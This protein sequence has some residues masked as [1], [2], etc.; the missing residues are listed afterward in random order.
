MKT[1]I[2]NWKMN[3]GVRE[4]VALARGTLL[5]LRGRVVAPELVI[6]PA[7][8]GLSEVHKVVARSSVSLGAQDV[9]W[10][11]QG[12]YTGAVSGRMLTELGVEYV[13]V[14]HSERRQTFG[15]T[16]E[17]IAKKVA[18]VRSHSMTPIVCVGE[19]RAERDQGL[20]RE[21]VQAQVLSA[22]GEVR[23][24][25]REQL[26]MA[27]E[28]VWAIGTGE[29]PDV[30]EVVQMHEFV[31]QLV[32]EVVGETETGS[33]RVLYGGSVDGENAY[34]FLREPEIDGVLV[35]SAS[36]KLNQF[37]DIVKAAADVLESQF[38]SSV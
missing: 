1:I 25:G 32:Q 7:F 20:A 30:A 8:V 2:A 11:E 18:L 35:G 26:M 6:C 17:Q 5:T 34:Q 36:V 10:E 16:D 38:S 12:A 21:R 13:I 23:L 24:R 37:K 19:T 14:G 27:Y 15:E 33:I 29:T 31:R 28:P 4:S 9:F 22:L 3:A